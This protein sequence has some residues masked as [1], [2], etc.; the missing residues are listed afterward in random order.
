MTKAHG[1][2]WPAEFHAAPRNSKKRRGIPR[3][4]GIDSIPRNTAIMSLELGQITAVA[5]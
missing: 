1:F 3:C 4:R 5:D 2:P